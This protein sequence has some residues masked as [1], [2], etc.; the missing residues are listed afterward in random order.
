MSYGAYVTGTHALT[1]DLDEIVSGAALEA[2]GLYVDAGN[3]LSARAGDVAAIAEGAG[4]AAGNAVGMLVDAGERVRVDVGR[5]QAVAP[6]GSGQ[7]SGLQA[8]AAGALSVNAGAIDVQAGE[9]AW[10]IQA[11]S[12]REL[13]PRP[14]VG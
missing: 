2:F 3:D 7:A 13:Y 4:S 5:V 9:S 10:G 6:G 12:G 14:R 8:V 1:V 11:D